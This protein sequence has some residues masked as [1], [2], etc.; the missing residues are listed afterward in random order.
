MRREGG[1]RVSRAELVGVSQPRISGR[2]GHHAVCDAIL[3]EGHVLITRPCD[4]TAVRRGHHGSK[5]GYAP[6][7]VAG[8]VEGVHGILGRH[9]GPEVGSIFRLENRSEDTLRVR[10]VNAA[11]RNH[12]A[13]GDKQQSVE[14]L[15]RHAPASDHVIPVIKG[16]I[17]AIICRVVV[18]GH[19]H[20]LVGVRHQRAEAAPAQVR[21]ESRSP[22]PRRGPFRA[23][24]RSGPDCAARPGLPEIAS[25]NI[26]LDRWASHVQTS[27]RSHGRSA[28]RPGGGSRL[29]RAARNSLARLDPAR[30][31]L[32]RVDQQGELSAS[33][34]WN[35]Q[36]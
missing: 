22:R 3:V 14:V 6:L 30:A 36:P 24:Y 33:Y 26:R 11:V 4:H 31:A 15:L 18:Q 19:R 16:D 17:G 20:A 13:A 34:N 8:Q 25:A 9:S 10:H 5:G 32:P 23:R 27:W 35:S 28:G 7:H 1:L 2:L 21:A 12:G 29:A